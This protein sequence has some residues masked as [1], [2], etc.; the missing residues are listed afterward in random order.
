MRE[1]VQV[2]A[3]HEIICVGDPAAFAA[4]QLNAVNVRQVEVAQGTAP[5]AAAAADGYRSPRDMWRLSRAVARL[6]PDVFFS[7]SVYSYFPLLPGRRRVVVTVHD[8]IAERFPT[9]T[10]P[11]KRAR[12]FWWMKVGLALRQARL[13]LT[14]SDYAAHEI[15]TVLRVPAARI[16]VALE[17][18]A[19]EY[20][21]AT[22]VEVAAAAATVGLPADAPWFTYV[23]GFSPH[24]RID[25][26]LR[27]H[28]D[29]A[30]SEDPV[31]HLLLVGRQSG[32]VFLTS[33]EALRALVAALG[34]SALVHWTGFVADDVLRA[35]HTGAVASLLPSESEGFGLPAVE[36]AACGTP[37]IATRE[38]P[39]PQLLAGGGHF[40]TPGDVAALATAMRQL[41]RHPEARRTMGD[42]AL[43]GAAALTWRRTAFATLAALEEAAA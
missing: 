6:A 13:V 21:P 40:V 42:A 20:F 15:A 1:L 14:V 8:A 41:L 22:P 36:A 2:A 43:R 32:D 27:A 23:G 16:R 3:R 31:P 38:S 24:K 9:L 29:V 10:L 37:V 11:S 35:L 28:A 12:L 26:I 7:P 39:L 18:P 17:A 34:T 5:T 4:M 33:G 19:P 30:L 25:V